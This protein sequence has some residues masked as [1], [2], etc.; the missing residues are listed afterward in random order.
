MLIK[1]KKR[2]QT[3][4][5]LK[6]PKIFDSIPGDVGD[7]EDLGITEEN[8]G[9]FL[10]GLE[11]I[12]SLPGGD[13]RVLQGAGFLGTKEAKDS[14]D[15]RSSPKLVEGAKTLYSIPGKLSTVL[16]ATNDG[17]HD[18]SDQG[19][20]LFGSTKSD[21][22]KGTPKSGTQG[23]QDSQTLDMTPDTNS[24]DSSYIQGIPPS[25]VKRAQDF[26]NLRQDHR[27]KFARRTL[28]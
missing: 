1:K 7:L 18:D 26:R 3:K 17:T 19:R 6:L 10:K 5:L 27:Y 24:R 25:G 9:E 11:S 22:N 4:R 16:D 20:Y 28:E 12:E 8:A 2:A 14:Q 15:Y 23:I 13:S 21:S